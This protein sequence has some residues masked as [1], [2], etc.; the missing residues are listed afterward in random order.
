MMDDDYLGDGVY[1]S[2]DGYHVI[3]D[4]RGQD[5]TTRIALDNHVRAALMNYISRLHDELG[6]IQ[7][8]E[9]KENGQ[10]T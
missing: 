2:W 8:E 1:A 9:K 6:K 10:N 3:L 5:S 4:L 7:T